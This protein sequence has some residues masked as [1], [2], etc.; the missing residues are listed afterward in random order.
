VFALPVVTATTDALIQFCG[1]NAIPLLVTT[2]SAGVLVHE[3]ASLPQRLAIAF[4]G[5]KEGCSLALMDAASLRVEIPINPAVQSLNVSA[6]AAITLYARLG[7]GK[8]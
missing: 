1:A 5:E 8:P 7:A 3:I 2:P 6:A 4:G